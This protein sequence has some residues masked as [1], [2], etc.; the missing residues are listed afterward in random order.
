LPC[1]EAAA[2]NALDNTFK[3]GI[4][5][6]I[7]AR[8]FMVHLLLHPFKELLGDK[9]FLHSRIIL[10][11]KT[12]NTN[13]EWVKKHSLNVTFAEWFTLASTDAHIIHKS[14]D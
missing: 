1:N 6:S 2:V 11:I 9:R 13:V 5:L 8:A 7:A 10:A 12:V 4:V 3:D 14:C